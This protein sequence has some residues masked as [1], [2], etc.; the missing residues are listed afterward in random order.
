MKLSRS[1]VNQSIEMAIEVFARYDIHLP[2]FAFWSP[3]DWQGQNSAADE[4]RQCRLGWDVTDFGHGNCEHIGRTLF[5][6]RN[7]SKKQPG[8]PKPYAEKLLFDPEGQR[9]PAHFH[10]SKMED[11][12][13]RAGGNILVQLTAVD[14]SNRPRTKPLRVQLDAQSVM[15]EP[16]GIIKLEP[17]QSLCIPPR[18]IHQFWAEEGSGVT[19]SSEVSSLCDDLE[20]NYFLDPTARFPEIEPD[21]PPRHYLC[22]EYPYATAG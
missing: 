14:D 9:A 11:I 20:D 13:N 10:L 12:I 4:I 18:T 15:L 3:V 1:A 17:G 16:G 7:G 2:R 22:H 19:V 5:T 6:L 8:Y 21:E